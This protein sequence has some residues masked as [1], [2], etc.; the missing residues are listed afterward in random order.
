[1]SFFK[2]LFS[3][4]FLLQ[5][6]LAVL[7]LILIAFIILKWLDFSTNQDQRITVPNLAR[8][9][10]DRVDLKLEELD[11][12]REILDSANYNPD[13]PPYSVID[14]VPLPGKQVKENRK[15]YLTLNP[16]G[17][18]KVEIP[19]NLIR[20]TR[21]QVEPTLR[22]LGFEIGTITYKPDVA[23][24]VVLEMRHQGALVEPGM[25][26]MKTSKI[27]LVLGDGSGRY[28]MEEEQ[29]TTAEEQILNDLE[30]EEYDF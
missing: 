29:D 7:A 8:M 17:F 28:G 25:K 21:R 27:D 10:L 20:R 23:K 1:M 3:K 16:S 26:L 4:T 6:V 13:Y 15:I 11:L 19:E 5:L 30:D 2:F 9:S 22:S 18:T 12:R 24:D 14:Q